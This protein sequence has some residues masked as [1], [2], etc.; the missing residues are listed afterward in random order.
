[1]RLYLIAAA[2]FW[3]GVL[4]AEGPEA[5]ATGDLGIVIER[6][7][8]SLQ[9]IETS[10]NSLLA[11][12]PGLGDLSHASAV[13]SRD[14]RFAYIF[15]RDG[16]LTK[17]DLLVMVADPSKR[18]LDTLKRLHEVTTEMEIKYN[19]LALIINRL[20][21]D[22]LPQFA[23]VL[24]EQTG[25]DLLIGIPDNKELA[26]FSEAGRDLA[27]LPEANPVSQ[28]IDTMLSDL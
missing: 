5:R 1:M 9:L 7:H 3:A 17:V 4:Q 14:E 27:D 10:G 13:F 23:A 25:A 6:E 20:R 2:L 16:G 24:K 18:G 26:D 28:K 11:E 15:G 19:K 12:I 8:G 22:E 21:R